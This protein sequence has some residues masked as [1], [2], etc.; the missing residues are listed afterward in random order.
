MLCESAFASKRGR[1]ELQWGTFI[2]EGVASGKYKVQADWTS[3][4]TKWRERDSNKSG[5]INGIWLGAVNSNE[6]EITLP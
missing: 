1:Y 2:F 3:A 6:V 5:V 4:E